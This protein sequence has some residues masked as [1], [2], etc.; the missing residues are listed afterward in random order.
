VGLD[1]IQS[2]LEFPPLSVECGQV[3]GRGFGRVQDRGDQS[4]RAYVAAVSALT[5][6]WPARVYSIGRVAGPFADQDLLLFHH[7]AA[8]SGI[9]RVNPL[10]NLRHQKS[11]FIVASWGALPI[12]PSWYHNLKAHPES[13]IEIGAKT[14]AVFATE[15]SPDERST[16][17][18]AYTARYPALIEY[19]KLTAE[20]FPSFG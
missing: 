6:S 16:V 12:N 5:P 18:P 14:S 2:G 7:R 1:F 4:A 20:S 10:C 8:R 3:H 17:W 9:E 13:T 15:L 11:L 19:E